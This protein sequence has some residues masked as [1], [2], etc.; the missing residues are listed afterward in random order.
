MFTKHPLVGCLEGCLPNSGY[1]IVWN[2]NVVQGDAE[3]YV[4]VYTRV[5]TH[6]HTHIYIYI[7]IIEYIDV[8]LSLNI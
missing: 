6:T 7:H 2:E 8:L 5:H 4:Y 3:M 1:Q